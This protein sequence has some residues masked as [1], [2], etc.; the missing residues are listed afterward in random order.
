MYVSRS[1]SHS[2]EHTVSVADL[3]P[4]TEMSV[5]AARAHL[6][7]AVRS[8]HTAPVALTTRGRRTAVLVDAAVY[9]RLVD[10]WEDYQDVLA[11]DEAKA[12]DDGDRVL[13]EDVMR[14]LGL[15]WRTP[16]P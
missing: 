5:S 14:D 2:Q 9:D 7:E 1:A 4:Q 15:A 13:L 11:Y 6:A 3:H 10:E 8:A 16:S 12:E